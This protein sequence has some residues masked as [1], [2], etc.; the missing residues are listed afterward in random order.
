MKRVRGMKGHVD[1]WR[2][3]ETLI[4]EDFKIKP[5]DP[6]RVG[7]QTARSILSNDFCKKNDFVNF[8]SIF[9]NHFKLRFLIDFFTV[10]VTNR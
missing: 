7:K 2:E 6:W 5:T 1:K 4:S 10:F 8:F 3:M 9:M